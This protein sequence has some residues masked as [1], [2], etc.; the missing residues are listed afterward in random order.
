MTKSLSLP[1][2]MLALIFALAVL[3]DGNPVLALGCLVLLTLTGLVMIWPKLNGESFAWSRAHWA[4]LAYLAWQ[5]CLVFLSIVPE[6]SLLMYGVWVSLV[7]VT[8]ATVAL[9]GPGWRR[10]F[11]FFSGGGT[12]YGDLGNCR[13]RGHRY[14]G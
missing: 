8:Y 9:D 7:V 12:D 2:G 11:G 5:S 14:P 4:L 1:R 10:V 3:Y 13:I 6:N